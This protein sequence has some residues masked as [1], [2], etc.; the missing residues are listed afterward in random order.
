MIKPLL[1]VVKLGIGRILISPILAGDVHVPVASVRKTKFI[2]R[3]L[4]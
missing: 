4:K 2:G 1:G 3:L